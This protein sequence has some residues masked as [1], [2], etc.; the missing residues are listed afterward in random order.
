[1]C[2][3]VSGADIERAEDKGEAAVGGDGEGSGA[4]AETGTGEGPVRDSCRIS[5]C[6]AA[7]GQQAVCETKAHTK[8]GTQINN[9]LV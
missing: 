3:C 2:D 8:K 9:A 1:M 7:G 6:A 4:A 5:Q